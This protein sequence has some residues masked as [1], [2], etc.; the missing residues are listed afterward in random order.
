M[1]RLKLS[2]ALLFLATLVPALHA[3][4]GYHMDQ[5]AWQDAYV[6]DTFDT[7]PPVFW[8]P[9]RTPSPKFPF[10]VLV[11]QQNVQYHWGL[12]SFTGNGLVHFYAPVGQ[13][14]NYSFNCGITFDRS[15]PTE[16]RARWVKQG[17]QVQILLRKPYS[18]RTTTCNLKPAQLPIQQAAAKPSPK[19]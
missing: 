7:S 16:F 12:S 2:L 10:L 6:H 13:T 14:L 9:E 11:Q 18:T 1:F 17:S 5:F 19:H 15:L 8:V 3:Q 4:D